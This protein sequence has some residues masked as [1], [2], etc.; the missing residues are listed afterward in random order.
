MNKKIF[1]II[2]PSYN[3]E[4][5]IEQT[6]KSIIQQDKS[7]YEC[8]VVDGLSKD[9]TVNILEKYSNL[10]EN[11]RYISEKDNG[12]YDAMNKGIDLA[13]GQYLYFIG[14]G[15]RLFDDALKMINDNINCE[16][17]I[18]GNTYMEFEKKKQGKRV[19]KSDLIYEMLCHQGIFYNRNVF[20]LVGKYEK[21]Y[22]IVADNILNKK[23]F[24]DD[25]LVKKY[26][27]ID[28][29]HYLGGGVSQQIDIVSEFNNEDEYV[30]E[31]IEIFGEE[32]LKKLYRCCKN[33]NDK[34]IIAWGNGGEFRK[35]NLYKSVKIDYFVKSNIEK[36]EIFK[37]K[38]VLGREEL[39][40]ENKD[41]VFIFV[42]SAYYYVEIR[43][44]LENN[45]FDEFK[46]FMLVTKEILMI[47]NKLKIY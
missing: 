20:D 41:N 13:K 12:I 32:Y 23:I 6:L 45:Q 15:D 30:N 44:W 36:K 9:N 11:I 47:L 35:A 21:K 16:D 3:C 27:D 17:I 7:L 18:Y 28:I 19:R 26:V 38:N 31:L 29:A 40:N 39:L 25:T 33:I 14:A 43:E 37:G 2:I 22:R 5:L 1:S 24:A 10:Y 8:I 4:N 46:N 34:R 42:Y